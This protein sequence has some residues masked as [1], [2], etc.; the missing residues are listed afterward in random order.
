ML[1]SH[2]FLTGTFVDKDSLSKLIAY[3]YF[4][5]KTD[6][7]SFFGKQKEVTEEVE[8]NWEHYLNARQI[9]R[10]DFQ[11]KEEF[12]AKLMELY[13]TY[14]EQTLLFLGDLSEYS[15]PL[16]E[17]ML[18]ILEEPPANLQIVLYAKSKNNI[19]PTIVSRCGFYLL[20]ESFVLQNLEQNLLDKV[21]KKL[22]EIGATVKT[23]VTHPD[24]FQ[25]PDLKTVE[26]EELDFWLWQI[27]YYLE[28][29]YRKNQTYQIS[30]LIEKVRTAQ[31]LNHQNLQKKFVLGSVKI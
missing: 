3:N 9:I 1:S 6:F 31:N 13:Q 25:L 10:T 29:I 22:P 4:E 30:A 15:L 11:G 16:Q 12:S 21:K 18:R 26:R 2:I 20:P 5:T 7:Q 23:L 14:H 17:G 28:A 8:K 27:G 24:S 19:L